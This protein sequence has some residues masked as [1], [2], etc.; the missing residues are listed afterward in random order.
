MI[1]I[2]TN[3][4]NYF[5]S[6]IQTSII[7]KLQKLFTQSVNKQQDNYRFLSMPWTRIYFPWY[8]II[9]GNILSENLSSRVLRNENCHI[10]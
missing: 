8:S 6:Y 10:F 5:Y 4:N 7:Y 1:E 3:I 9:T 2:T